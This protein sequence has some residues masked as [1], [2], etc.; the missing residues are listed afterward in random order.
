M[1]SRCSTPSEGEAQEGSCTRCLGVLGERFGSPSC[2][3]KKKSEDGWETILPGIEPSFIQRT[4][5]SAVQ[6]GPLTS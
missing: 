3:K 4:G 5:W 1:C 2:R 6:E